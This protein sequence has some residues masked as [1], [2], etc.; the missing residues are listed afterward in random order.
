MNRKFSNLQAT[1]SQDRCFITMPVFTNTW[2]HYNRNKLRL[3]DFNAANQS[4]LGSF[5]KLK[6]YPLDTPIS[7]HH[8]G[9]PFDY[10]FNMPSRKNSVFSQQHSDNKTPPKNSDLKIK[11]LIDD[12]DLAQF[13]LIADKLYGEKPGLSKKRI[14]SPKFLDIRKQYTLDE[15]IKNYNQSQDSCLRF[16][17][18]HAPNQQHP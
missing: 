6:F 17:N 2:R 7:N 16:I 18:T 1:P 9:K 14:I 4:E 11:H 13:K 5:D 8:E 15:E 3:A 12:G 10:N